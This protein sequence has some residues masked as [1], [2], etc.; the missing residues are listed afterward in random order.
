MVNISTFTNI[1]KL[2]FS[3][4]NSVFKSKKLTNYFQKFIK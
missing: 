4:E 3:L 1:F 2:G